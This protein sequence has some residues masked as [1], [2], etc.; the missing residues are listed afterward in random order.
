MEKYEE[1]MDALKVST[2]E[3]VAE[4]ER[5]LEEANDSIIGI[6][7]VQ[8]SITV[9]ER[10]F[11]PI[12]IMPISVEGEAEQYQEPER[13]NAMA[14]QVESQCRDRIESILEK[15]RDREKQMYDNG[16]RGDSISSY[17][18]R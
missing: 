15:L 16:V 3:A 14:A 2:D 1:I 11:Y 7:K 8:D 5:V 13:I 10:M 6:A 4:A 17:R 12:K 18:F 9:T